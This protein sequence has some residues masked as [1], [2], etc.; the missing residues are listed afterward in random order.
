MA[1]HRLDG[2]VHALLFNHVAWPKNDAD[3]FKT[4]QEISRDRLKSNIN[5][6]ID[7]PIYLQMPKPLAGFV[8]SSGYDRPDHLPYEEAARRLGDKEHA[9]FTTY[10]DQAARQH[11]KLDPHSKQ[12]TFTHLHGIGSWEDAVEPSIATVFHKPVDP[13]HIQRISADVGSWA[14]QHGILA[15]YPHEKGDEKVL[16][17]R[18]KTHRKMSKL[19]PSLIGEIAKQVTHHFN[20]YKNSD[21]EALMPGRTIIPN[22][23]GTSDVMVWIPPWEKQPGLVHDAF[24][25]IAANLGQTQ[26]VHFWPGNGIVFGG[27]SPHSWD[28]AKAFSDAKK[29]RLARSNFRRALFNSFAQGPQPQVTEPRKLQQQRSPAGT[30][31]VVRGVYYPPGRIIPTVE[32]APA[33]KKLTLQMVRDKFKNRPIKL[34]FGDMNE[35]IDQHLPS[36]RSANVTPTVP[37]PDLNI[38]EGMALEGGLKHHFGEDN[39]TVAND[40][41]S[42]M[43]F[44]SDSQI[45]N[46]KASYTIGSSPQNVFSVTASGPTGQYYDVSHHSDTPFNE[47]RRTNIPSL[48]AV[49]DYIRNHRKNRGITN[50]DAE[51]PEQFMKE[52]IDQ[53]LPPNTDHAENTY[54][55]R[56]ANIHERRVMEAGLKHHFGED[57]VNIVTSGGDYDTSPDSQSALA[58][59]YAGY[60]IGPDENNKFFFRPVTNRPGYEVFHLTDLMPVKHAPSLQSVLDYIRT[61]KHARKIKNPDAE[62]M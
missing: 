15:F 57:N 22:N 13:L 10:L 37:Y 3:Q 42:N 1:R 21:G 44:P 30:G 6:H 41:E 23:N 56:A 31:I 45:P 9:D 52:P 12:D 54:P 61:H 35:P 43:L 4:F 24:S 60:Q 26:P 17:M 38:H 51:L 14:R 40:H 55:S 8:A 5:R 25:T 33:G 62:G 2:D 28:E 7:N 59:F 49:L 39:V 32:T 20:Q 47:S 36:P 53:H 29:R 48:Q 18:V 16:H 58:G 50:P 34:A 19:T 11:L 27:T 46:N